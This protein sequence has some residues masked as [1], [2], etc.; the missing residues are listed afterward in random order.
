MKKSKLL[1]LLLSV[2]CAVA[3]CFGALTAMA[4]ETSGVTVSSLWTTSDSSV[5]TDVGAEGGLKVTLLQGSSATLANEVDFTAFYA[6]LSFESLS[7]EKVTLRF[8]GK[9][10]M[11]SSTT[12]DLTFISD[13]TVLKAQVNGGE[14]KEIANVQPLTVAFTP[15]G[16]FTVNGTEIGT[17]KEI[18]MPYGTLGIYNEKG[19]VAVVTLT[20]LNGETFQKAAGEKSVLDSKAPEIV[21]SKNFLNA[22]VP[23]NFRATY[24]YGLV[25]AVSN[26][27]TKTVSVKPTDSAI[28]E[29]EYSKYFEK[30]VVS[31]TYAVVIFHKAGVYE[32][33][34]TVQD[35]SGKSAERKETVTVEG[36]DTKAPKFQDGMEDEYQAKLN[37][38]ASELVLG[39]SFK[40]PLPF[41]EDDYTPLGLM[42]YV[43]RYM[44][45]SASTWTY[46]TITTG[47]PAFT[48]SA[49]GTYRVQI[50]PV[51]LAENRAAYDEGV[52][53]EFTVTLKDTT[54]PTVTINVKATQ[55]VGIAVKLSDISITE[56]S[57]YETTKVLEKF[58]NETTK[59]EVVENVGDTFTPDTV[60]TFRYTVT[61][62]DEYLNKTEVVKEFTVIEPVKVNQVKSWISENYLSVIFIGIAFL[63]LVAIIVLEIVY[64]KSMKKKN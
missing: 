8:K 38:M 55:Y 51:D 40:M 53:P 49:V 5:L 11:D 61:V 22:K 13:G 2:C 7:F 50:L 48:P 62:K 32:L 29:T 25:D 26:I 45:P 58:N 19:S 18:Y 34:F 41:V 4:D 15:A 52:C 31:D 20:N 37:D 10:A 57:T 28:A 21:M 30:G 1:I 24:Y 47:R 14:A 46:S 44:A 12:N 54:V 23:V 33:T 59:W 63:C 16:V 3:T 36:T 27:S 56:T 39:E 43:L 9:H 60:G 6:E 42:R 64:K 17:G 35:A